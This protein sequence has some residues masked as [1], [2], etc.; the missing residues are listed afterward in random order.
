LTA[1]AGHPQYP[2]GQQIMT[3]KSQIFA[4]SGR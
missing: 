1:A 4:S 2:A 3:G